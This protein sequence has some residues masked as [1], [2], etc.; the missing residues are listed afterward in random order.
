MRVC[1]LTFSIAEFRRARVVLHSL[2]DRP[3]RATALYGDA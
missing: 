1:D 3:V 2:L